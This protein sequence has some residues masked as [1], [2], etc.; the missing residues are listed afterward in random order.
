[1]LIVTARNPLQSNYGSEGYQQIRA[2]LDTWA[3]VEGHRVLAV[4]DPGDMASFG[5]TA[6]T[7][8]PADVQ[9][10]I[11]G[12]STR[13][14]S[15][16]DGVLLAGGN[17]II[18][19]WTLNNPVADRGT[20]L[21]LTVMT[22]NP[23]GAVSETL[24]EYL[25][26]SCPIGRLAIPDEA[27]LKQFLGSI[28]G[29]PHRQPP[30]AAGQPGTALFVN[31]DWLEFSQRVAQSTPNPQVWHLSPGYELDA[32][33]SQD[34]ARQT[35]Y[36]NLHGFSG[37]ADWQGYSTIQ[38]GFVPA[39]TPDGLNRT[40]VSGAVCFAECC[41]GAQIAGRTTD[42][43]CALKLVQEGASLVGATGLAFGSYIA[44]DLMLEDA[45][46]LARAFF[47]AVMT[48][49]T[50][51]ESLTV[52]RKSYLA[53]ASENQVGQIWQLKQKTL[54]QFVLLGN[55]QTIY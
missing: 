43:S 9:L 31:S 55:P 19:F 33:T 29:L 3:S 6:G 8:N 41:Y 50:I 40:W 28:D 53:D 42:N 4:D 30:V 10:A 48:G 21:D 1:M 13:Y 18:P 34:A 54:L 23:Y 38:R 26:P 11:R 17:S 32:E 20:D 52:A 35:L 24:S 44:S 7:N 15:M 14:P 47:Q 27:S 46:F 37:Q 12:V 5:L 49:S 39:V 51:G 16:V 2:A 22:D 25:A 36:F 45:D